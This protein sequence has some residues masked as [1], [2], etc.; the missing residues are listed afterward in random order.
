MVEKKWIQDLRIEYVNLTKGEK[1]VAGYL[2][3]REGEIEH[4]TLRQC[5]DGAQTGQPTV[6]RTLRR[7]GFQG[8][9]Q[10]RNEVLKQSGQGNSVMEGNS[11]GQEPADGSLAAKRK[12]V[13]TRVIRQD[14]VVLQEM[15]QGIQEKEFQEVIQLLKKARSVEIYGAERSAFVAG[16]L[17]GRLLHMGISCRTYA[18]LFL[19]KVSAEYLDARSVVIA[20]SQSGTTRM[21]A[22]AMRLAKGSGAKMIGIL[23]TRECPIADYCD[24]VFVTPMIS[25]EGGE[26]AAS[27]IAQFGFIDLLCEG[28]VLSDEKRFKENIIKS[29]EKFV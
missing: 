16:E 22:E 24:Y 20:I 8:W 17:E 29:R 25:F 10:F 14:I 4:M 3:E 18:D 27:R 12:G 1:K 23:G 26:K 5:A 7:L 19:Q 28:L 6:V 2:L 13:P 21:V 9:Q 15:L 11:L